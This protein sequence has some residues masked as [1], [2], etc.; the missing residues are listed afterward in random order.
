MI[1][2]YKFRSLIK[3]LEV[4]RVRTCETV[5]LESE[6]VNLPGEKKRTAGGIN[7]K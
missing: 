3:V 6:K 2:K 4:L 1:R 7:A 5:I